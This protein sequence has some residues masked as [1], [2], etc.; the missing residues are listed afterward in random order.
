VGSSD[1]LQEV[2]EQ[3]AA[4]EYASPV[5]LPDPR[6]DR[7][8]ARMTALIADTFPAE[9]VLDA[10]CGDGRFL[11]GIARLPNRPSRL[12]GCDISERI[13]RTAAAAVERE[14]VAAEFVRSNLERLPFADESF[15]RVLCV[16]VVE[17]LLDPVSGV[18]ELARVLRPGGTLVLSTDN[19]NN[20]VS[21][22]LNLPRSTL[23]RAFHL[24]GA[25]AKVSFPHGSFTC[26]EVLE[27]VRA[28]GLDVQHLETFRFHL[29]GVNAEMVSRVLNAADAALPPH[30]WGDIVAVVARKPFARGLNGAGDS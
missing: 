18:G 27:A 16:Q 5:A 26:D 25:R 9:S 3:R 12:V 21:R 1:H 6:V 29:D 14:G 30:R 20:V 28:S 23:V 7:K 22:L 11:V 19:A 13:L 2:Y 15:D 4:L 8:Y 24:R 10:G 17:H